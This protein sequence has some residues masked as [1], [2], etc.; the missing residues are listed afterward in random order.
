MM[1]GETNVIVSDG[2][3]GNIALKTAEGTAKFITDN[4]KNLL[5]KRLSKLSLIFSYYALK[6]LKIN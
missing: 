2:F 4:L 1:D 5:Q 6:S 3:T